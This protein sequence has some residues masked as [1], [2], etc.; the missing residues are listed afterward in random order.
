V[1]PEGAAEPAQGRAAWGRVRGTGL[2]AALFAV[3]LAT[4]GL[5][6]ARR[7]RWRR[8]RSTSTST[9]PPSALRKMGGYELLEVLGRGGMA[10]TFRARRLRDGREVAV[11]VPHETGD[12]SYPARFLR[13]GRLGEALHH[14]RLVRIF[15]A[16]EEQGRAFLAMELIP[17]TTLRSVI[18]A[19]P[20]GLPLPRALE[21][22]R[23]IAEALDY[24]HSKGVVHRDL[25]PE[26]I[27]LLPDG[28]LKVMDF[29]VAR[30][31]G[32]PG[33]TAAGFLFGSPLYAA[34]E[35]VDAGASA[36]SARSDLYSLGI[37]LFELLEGEPP[38]VAESVYKVLEMQQQA[39]L[40]EPHHLRRPLPP[41]VWSVLERLLAKDPEQRYASAQQLLVE[42]DQLL[43]Q[44]EERAEAAS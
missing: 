10:T 3:V 4:G 38:F 42:L 23:D 26:N 13:E 41:E 5:L 20:R 28:S 14:P 30:V 21:I 18:E 39:P 8:H 2:A 25:K 33:L 27:M 40:P 34:P 1:D 31:E 6:L 7:R 36:A 24:A 15:E 17:G 22:A 11:K 43:F 19:A 44:T 16:G 29:G 12:E 37:V 35:Q 32:Q 9:L